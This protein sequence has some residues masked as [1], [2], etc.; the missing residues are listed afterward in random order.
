MTNYKNL[1]S[2]VRTAHPNYEALLS[3]DKELTQALIERVLWL[4]WIDDQLLAAVSCC[5][6]QEDADAYKARIYRGVDLHLPPP[7]IDTG[8]RVQDLRT[9]L[10][11]IRCDVRRLI[12]QHDAPPGLHCFLPRRQTEGCSLRHWLLTVWGRGF[13]RQELADTLHHLD[14]QPVW[15]DVGECL[16]SHRW[17]LQRGLVRSYRAISAATGM[18]QP[19][20]QSCSEG[21]HH[22]E[23][24][25]ALSCQRPHVEALHAYLSSSAFQAHTASRENNKHHAMEFHVHHAQ[26]LPKAT[27]LH[28]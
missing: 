2:N 25:V 27:R 24:H 28:L 9:A 12:L 4:V 11:L 16:V 17:H 26:A 8:R 7:G 10:G 13:I 5:R 15:E 22:W 3:L 6:A 19:P 14:P 1:V 23:R 21:H 20:I 18:C